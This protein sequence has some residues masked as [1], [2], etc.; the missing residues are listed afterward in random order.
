MGFLVHL[1]Q[2]LPFSAHNNHL[3]NRVEVERTLF[4]ILDDVRIPAKTT[5]SIHI[6]HQHRD[7]SLFPDPEVFDPN[8]FLPENTINR[9]P[10]SYIPF[11][12]GPR[13]CIG[14]C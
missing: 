2:Y 11:S 14:K 4:N 9:H 5:I 8:R 13:N 7:P 1:T 3:F 12:A 6:F 10:Y